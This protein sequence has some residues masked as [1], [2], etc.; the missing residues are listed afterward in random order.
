M[1]PPPTSKKTSSLLWLAE[2]KIIFA[3]RSACYVRNP[4]SSVAKFKL[5]DELTHHIIVNKDKTKVGLFCSNSFVIYDISTR[6]KIWSL[7]IPYGD[8]YSATFSPSDDIII[9]HK[10]KSSLNYKQTFNLPFSEPNAVFDITCN[11]KTKE[12]MYPSS[13]KT[14]SMKSLENDTIVRL[15]RIF[16]YENR[17]Y[18]IASASYTPH[19]AYIILHAYKKPEI[20]EFPTK[21]FFLL[22]N[23]IGTIINISSSQ[24]EQKCSYYD[25]KILP[26]S[27][28]AAALCNNRGIHFFDIVKKKEILSD[29][30][31]RG[32][33]YACKNNM[34]VFDFDAH[35]VYYTVITQRKSYLRKTPDCL[36]RYIFKQNIY[37]PYVILCNYFQEIDLFIP[38]DI[39]SL[40]IYYFYRLYT[41]P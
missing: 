29:S 39:K 5:H 38:K 37:V 34:N 8:N 28:I 36:L 30:I 21:E 33:S 18:K 15:S 41:Q 14:F 27:L 12:I 16:S 19:N 23:K 24:N 11:Q 35:A 10:G 6:K 31:D 3:S 26:N 7:I 9:Y 40:L 20:G 2:D 22:H 13:N 32:K 25:V 4:F 1:D 17:N